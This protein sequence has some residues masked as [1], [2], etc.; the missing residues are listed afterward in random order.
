MQKISIDD[1]FFDIG[2]DSII[3]IKFQIEALNQNLNI[4][5][6]DIFKYPT[7]RML[8][9]NKN[10]AKNELRFTIDKKYD[11]TD[12]NNILIKNKT[13]SN[14]K[15]SKNRVLLLGS[16]GFLG[17]HILD[18]YFSNNP[19]NIIY[20]IVRKK[21]SEDAQQRLKKVLNYYFGNKYNDYF[22]QN[23]IIVL[24][25]DICEK[26][27]GLKIDQFKNLM[28]NIDI[29]INS[30]ALVK[31]YGDYETF[32]KINIDA[33]KSLI[34]ICKKYHKKFYHVST[35]SVSGSGIDNIGDCKDTN[36]KYTFDETCLYINQQLNNIYIYTKFE[37]EK[38]ILE[39]INHGLDATILRIGNL[40]NRYSDGQFQI[41]VA[42]NAFVNK[43]KS[44]INLNAIQ[45]AFFK[46]SIELTPVDLCADAIIKIINFYHTFSVLHLANTNSVKLK[47]LVEYINN[48]GFSVKPMSDKNF[49]KRVTKYLSTDTLKNSIT[50]IITDLSKDKLLDYTSNIILQADITNSFLN[51]LDFYWPVLD[52]LYFKKYFDFFKKI[53]Y[54]TKNEED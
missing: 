39:E 7:I 32:S 45:R 11:Y 30:A 13:E 36:Q 20:C 3:A 9:E 12:I 41:N 4:S 25:G 33:T 16:T 1:N 53:N 47:K 8:S 48:A 40:T 27:F 22:T 50:G 15:L 19:D 51:K 18:R 17:A 52:D 35:L 44:I 26:D 29:V 21:S 43:I 34:D 10:T 28:D 54:F 23:K 24:E 6:G 31:H 37:A 2:F 14:C 49:A 5:Y 38:H 42:E 46:H